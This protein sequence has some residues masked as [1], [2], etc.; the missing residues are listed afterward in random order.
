M[1]FDRGCVFGVQ[2]SKD[3][4]RISLSKNVKLAIPVVAVA[5]AA[6]SNAFEMCLANFGTLKLRPVMK[7]KKRTKILRQKRKIN[8]RFNC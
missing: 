3:A 2:S 1:P 5:R 4:Y 6:N 7:K 8:G